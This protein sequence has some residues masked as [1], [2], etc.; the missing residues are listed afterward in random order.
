MRTSSDGRHGVACPA[1]QWTVPKGTNQTPARV[2]GRRR[3][4]RCPKEAAASR[5]GG[6]IN[7][8]GDA[9]AKEAALIPNPDQLDSLITREES[10]A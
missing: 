2:Y 1:T 5:E 7:A 10:G 3:L 6:G 9:E 4:C 8:S